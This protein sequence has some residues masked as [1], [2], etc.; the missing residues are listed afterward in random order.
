MTTYTC[1]LCEG[2][3]AG[4][5]VTGLCLKCCQSKPRTPAGWERARRERPARRAAELAVARAAELAASPLQ[6]HLDRLNQK[7]LPYATRDAQ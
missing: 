5:T 3:T 1:Q 2:P 6:A 7:Y 4:R